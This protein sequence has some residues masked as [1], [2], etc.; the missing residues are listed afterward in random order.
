MSN[1]DWAQAIIAGLAIL[2][3]FGGIMFQHYLEG[4]KAQ[5]D[6]RELLAGRRRELLSLVE[7]ALYVAKAT[8]SELKEK[9]GVMSHAFYNECIVTVF[10]RLL[11]YRDFAKAFD[12]TTI[13]DAPLW[14][15]WAYFRQILEVTNVHL[16][17]EIQWMRGVANKGSVAGEEKFEEL[18]NLLVRLI[19]AGHAILTPALSETDRAA[20]MA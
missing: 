16:D 13:A 2:A 17:A 18:D 11:P 15:K 6:Q 10:A 9:S 14:A 20:G 8:R 19:E 12:V 5:R 4:R 3:G 1:A 7:A